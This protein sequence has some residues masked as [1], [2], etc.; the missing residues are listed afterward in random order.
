MAVTKL[1]WVP[2]LPFRLPFRLPLCLTLCLTLWSVS[3]AADE[4]SSGTETVNL[5]EQQLLQNPQQIAQL[6][7]EQAITIDQIPN[8][9][10]REDACITCHTSP[11]QG[12]QLSL[13][14]ADTLS[15]CQNCHD[16]VTEQTHIHAVGMTPSS[17]ML[18]HMPD[19]FKATLT[20]PGDKINC[21]TCHN[22]I[23]QCKTD[24]FFQYKYNDIF[25]RD[26]PYNSRTGLCY[27]CHDKSKY[28][29]LNPHDQIDD[30]GKLLTEKCLVCHLK[31]PEELDTGETINADLYLDSD[32]SALCINCHRKIEHPSANL[33]FI[34][35][36]KPDHL[37]KPSTA[38][39]RQ[40]E[41][42]TVQN[43]VYLPL[44]EGTDRIFCATCHNPHE[45]GVIKNTKL[46]KGADS[47]HRLRIV[48]LCTNCH[49]V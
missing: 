45:R 2:R 5:E 30:Q 44:E 24:R 36:G 12:D 9:H 16:S 26:A 7:Q 4:P 25:L 1:L 37:V 6:L 33:S 34:K 17:K 15:G 13:R 41:K 19:N 38:Y 18:N 10:W 14:V 48:P 47:E 20:S 49:D 21:I 40:M 42:M 35:K 43:D 27:R 23:L 32:W 22:V 31:V 3:L 39:M 46:A 11:P 29:P 28:Q 8:P